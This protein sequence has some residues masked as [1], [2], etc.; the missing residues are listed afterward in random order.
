M[1]DD[2]AYDEPLAAALMRFRNWFRDAALPLWTRR[3]YDHE[4]GGFYEALNFDGAPSTGRPRRTRTQ[5]RQ[6]H[7]FTQAGLHGW[8]SNAEDIAAKGFEHFLN[9]ACPDQGAR[10]CVHHLADDGAVLD[11][12]RDLYDQAF[13][14]LACASRWQAAKDDRALVL[15]DKTLD[16]I[17]R[18]LSSPHGGWHESDRKELP[19]R[20]NPHMHLFE[21]FMAL[22]HATQNER[23]FEY[24]RHIISTCFSSFYDQDNG[25]IRERFGDAWNHDQHDHA[26]EPGHM[27]EW[28]WLLKRFENMSH[29]NFNA[30][31]STLYE[32]GSRLGEDAA[33]FGFVNN[34]AAFGTHASSGAK[35]LWPQTEYLRASLVQLAD[36]DGARRVTTLIDAMFNT[37]LNTDLAGL[38][39]DEFNQNAAPIAQDVP[40]SI[41]YHLLEAVSAAEAYLETGNCA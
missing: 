22:F 4:R 41:V 29:D 15:A 3:G 25:V 14:L 35:R 7:A 28:V 37:Y 5:T 38:W 8:Q 21:A 13:L 36:G 12:R 31:R 27:F 32:H 9:H 39:I 19:R 33:F 17:D 6:I 11:V 34:E 2:N 20:Q 18:E 30:E 40:A 24:A 10:G 23:Y 26:V 1:I 16:F